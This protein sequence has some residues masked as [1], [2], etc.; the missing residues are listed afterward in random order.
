MLDIRF[1]ILEICLL[2]P[3]FSIG[4]VSRRIFIIRKYVRKSV[5]VPNIFIVVEFQLSGNGR[6]VLNRDLWVENRDSIILPRS[7]AV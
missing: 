2:C 5:N 1:S 6:V 4:P 3:V 7:L